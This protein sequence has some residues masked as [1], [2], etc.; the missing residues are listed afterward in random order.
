M[1][2]P[3]NGQRLKDGWEYSACPWTYELTADRMLLPGKQG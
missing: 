1:T 3:F 2:E